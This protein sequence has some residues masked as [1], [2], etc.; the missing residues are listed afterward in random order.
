MAGRYENLR[1][2]VE[3]KIEGH[4]NGKYLQE[5]SNRPDDTATIHALVSFP[6]YFNLNDDKVIK[7]I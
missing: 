7:T 3:Q 1:R 5:A 4:W 2:Q 6:Y